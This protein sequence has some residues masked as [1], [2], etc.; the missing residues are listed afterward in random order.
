MNTTD[1]QML[2]MG[3]CSALGTYTY[4]R[5]AGYAGRGE[6]RR[7]AQLLPEAY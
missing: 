4:H 7:V 2:H 5:F 6:R 3:T 1:H